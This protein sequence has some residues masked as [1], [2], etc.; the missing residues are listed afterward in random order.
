MKKSE[1]SASLTT[2]IKKLKSNVKDKIVLMSIFNHLVNP[3]KTS[4]ALK[5]LKYWDKKD[6]SNDNSLTMINRKEWYK[7]CRTVIKSSVQF[8]DFS[9]TL[10]VIEAFYSDPLECVCGFNHMLSKDEVIL[11]VTVKDNITR[12][13]HFLKHYRKMGFS[14]FIFID[15]GSVD[16][17]FETLLGQN[18][19]ACY[20][21][22]VEYHAT[23]K[24]GWYNRIVA[25]YGSDRW[26]AVVDSDELLAYPEMSQLPIQKYTQI[27]NKR[28][29]D[30]VR[31]ILID[32]YPDGLLMDENKSDEE[33]LESSIYFDSMKGIKAKHIKKGGMRNRLFIEEV[34]ANPN[35]PV[36]L[37]FTRF[38]LVSSHIVFPR[39]VNYATSHGAV[40]LHYKFLP[41]DR[42]KYVQIAQDGNYYNS[43]EVYKII[44]EKF[45]DTPQINAMCENSIRF[46]PDTAWEHLPFIVNF[47]EGWDKNE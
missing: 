10:A 41:S 7:K 32:V 18:N 2:W 6:K 22:F 47:A 12:L 44:N 13:E 11:L 33:Y 29:C 39:S 37:R 25:H 36:L 4:K 38:F 14:Y 24:T 43:G 35:K 23:R 5:Q 31:A 19:I 15:N 1:K 42:K 30:F 26:Y 21:T 17:T 40:V 27:L 34:K 46:D 45:E 20:R 16:G 8:S 3:I 9:K 28:N